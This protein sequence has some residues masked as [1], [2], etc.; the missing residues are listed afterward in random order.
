M[1]TGGWIFLL[2]AWGG[3]IYMNIFSFRK[4]L[5]KKAKG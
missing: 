5:E 3:I 4:I 2:M 1:N